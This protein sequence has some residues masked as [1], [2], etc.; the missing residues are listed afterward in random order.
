[1]TDKQENGRW[2]NNRVENRHL[3]FRRWEKAMLRFRQ[4]VAPEAYQRP[5]RL[6][7]SLNQA[8][9]GLAYK[10]CATHKPNA[11]SFESVRA[12]Q[13]SRRLVQ[14]SGSVGV[15]AVALAAGS[16]ALAHMSKSHAATMKRC[17]TMS[18]SAM[19]KN[20]SCAAMMKTHGSSKESHS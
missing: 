10:D 7:Q 18:H 14:S 5:R 19:M 3:R 16:S 20:R 12:S 11:G 2:A 4:E 15:F 9:F 6:S 1:M 17:H 13:I 8:R